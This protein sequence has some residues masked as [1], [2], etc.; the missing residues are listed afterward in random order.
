MG[1][2]GLEV[3]EMVKIMR[4]QMIRCGVAP[5]LVDLIV[6]DSIW[7]YSLIS[8]LDPKEMVEA[9]RREVA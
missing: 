9:M 3:V 8:T 2:L 6:A 1:T 4:S 7:H 5:K